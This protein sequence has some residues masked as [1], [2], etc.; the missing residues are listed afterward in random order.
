M[1][2]TLFAPF[3]AWGVLSVASVACAQSSRVEGA[4]GGS[5]VTLFGIFDATLG[6]GTGSMANKTQLYSGGNSTSR[7]GFRGVE[8]LGGGMGASFWLEAGL[9]VDDGT[10]QST[11][12][13]NQ[14]SGS[15]SVGGLTFNRRATVSLTDFWGELRL[16]RDF[17]A[18]YRNRTDVDPFDNNGVGNI[19]PNAGTIAGPTSTRASNM[20]GYFLP[21]NL[22]GFFGEVQ[23]YMGEN[24]SGSPNYLVGN[25]NADDGDGY[26]GRLGYASGPFAIAVAAGKTKFAQTAST[27]DIDSANIGASWD[28]GVVDVSAGYY[29]DKVNQFLPV[30]ATGYVVG[31]IVPVFAFDQLKIAWSSYGTDAPGDP[32]ARKLS[33][34]Y[35]YNLSKRTALYASY[36]HVANSGGSSVAVNGG[37]TGPNQSAWGYDLGMRHRF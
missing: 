13:N 11:N 37:I 36:G 34:G 30:T 23:Y 8:D 18:H 10:G 14:P 6:Y 22:G 31:A 24:A 16:G 33:L 27:G 21:A 4:S 12:I 3:I 5:S 28:F 26:S 17:T 20:V 2:R 29:R 1:G 35:V 19:Q 15:T 9:N 32:Q 25:P 7:L